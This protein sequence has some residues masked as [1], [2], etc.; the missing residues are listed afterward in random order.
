MISTD[1]LRAVPLFADLGEDELAWLS[2][3]TQVVDLAVGE[4]PFEV[5]AKA[6]HMI[7][8]LSGAM[9]IFV[10]GEGQWRLFDTFRAGRITG[11]LPYSRMTHFRGKAN[12]IEPTRLATIRKEDF[13][14]MLHRIPILG[15]RLIG[16]MSDRVR[17]QARNNQHREKIMALGKLA[18]GLAH[19]LNNPAAAVQRATATLRERL[20]ALPTLVARVARHGLGEEQVCATERLRH[21]SNGHATTLLSA[22]E[23]SEC[24]DEMADWLDDRDVEES[25]MLADTFIDAG[26][27]PDD[28][29]AVTATLPEPAVPDMVN[30][31]ESTLAVDRLLGEIDAAA[32]RISK[33]IASVKDYSHMDRAADRQPTDVLMGL[34]STLTML[35]HKLKKKSI[36]IERAYA[37]ELPHADAY[38]DEL[39]QVWTNL[40]DNAIDA[41]DEGGTLRLEAETAGP[42]LVIR[43]IDDGHG[44][45]PDI[46]SRIFEPFFTTKPIGEGTGLGLDIVHR[47]VH[48]HH[49]GDIRIESEPGRTVIEVLLPL[50]QQGG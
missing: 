7:V 3:H 29:E 26:L 18:A 5:G 15:Q 19:E 27:K 20:E 6:D 34:E 22:L 32:A 48:E 46:Q 10:G 14:E 30:W 45:P 9:Q 31:L 40:I 44:I 11:I 4:A 13:P 41:M 50:T 24:E 42:T 38:P 1:E 36:R 12:T 39:N 2:A 16:L 23:R 8:V 37:P 25:W 43:L 49:D 35:G 33:L 47:I 28:L 17:T 21:K